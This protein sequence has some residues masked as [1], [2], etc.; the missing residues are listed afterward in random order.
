[1]QPV[2]DVV[3]VD[4]E[5]APRIRSGSALRFGSVAWSQLGLRL[6]VKLLP[7][8]LVSNMYGP[9]ETTCS[10]YF[11]PVSLAAGT[12]IVDGSCAK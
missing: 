10:L 3:G 6:S 2:V 11:A 12:G 7:S 5:R 4:V 1:M 8:S 9:V